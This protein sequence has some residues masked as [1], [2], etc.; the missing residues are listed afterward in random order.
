[1]C[2]NDIRVRCVLFR[3]AMEY[4]HRHG[5]FNNDISL[6]DFPDGSCGSASYMLAE[7]LLSYGTETIYVCGSS[8]DGSHAWLVVKDDRVKEASVS[9]VFFTD[10]MP[11]EIYNVMKSYGMNEDDNQREIRYAEDDIDGGLIIDITGDQFGEMPV[12]VGYMDRFHERYRIIDAQDYSEIRN[13]NI[14]NPYWEFYNFC[15]GN[16]INGFI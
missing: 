8:A 5:F 2:D 13:Q 1:M 10:E 7:Y 14:T 4:A 9:P 15:K 6:R 16:G 3:K 11:I 12:Y